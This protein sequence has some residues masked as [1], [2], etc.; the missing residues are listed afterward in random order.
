MAAGNLVPTPELADDIVA[1]WP[2]LKD[3]HLQS[4]ALGVAFANPPLF[5]EAAFR[6]QDPAFVADFVGHV[7]RALANRQD[8]A[9]ASALVRLLAAQPPS[10]DGL[11]ESSIETLAGALK[12]DVVP[13]WDAGL[14]SAF[15][16][17]LESPR[18]TLPGALLPLVARWD[19]RG[20]LA[21]ALRPVIARLGTSLADPS[22]A[23]DQ[24]GQVAVNLVG[25]RRL[26]ANVVPAVARLLGP[27]SSVGLQRRVI[28]AL[29][30]AA[31]P[32]IG[33][34]L[35]A[36]YPRVPEEL[37]E[38]LFGAIAK[39]GDWSMALVQALAD[40][41]ISTLQ[42]GPALLY[43]LRT[44][45]DKPVAA[46]ANEVIDLLKGPEQKEKEALIA[47]FRPEVEKPGNVENG[48]KLFLAN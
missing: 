9:Q 10:L 33:G 48:R 21:P 36:A 47:R 32:A 15:A 4:A 7:T 19:K 14:Q 25:V 3:K 16:K 41:K 23:D 12:A 46:R 45:A 11:K 29:G 39:R 35:V 28:D 30:S 37:H 26:D 42:L 17:L 5:L 34:E 24:R 22:L 44:H 13:V 2:A 8:A 6:A 18:P 27:P 38:A 1:V 43:R 31:D 20:E 40:K